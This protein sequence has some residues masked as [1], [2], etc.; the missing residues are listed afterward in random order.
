MSTALEGVL[1]GE[2][3]ALH[4]EQMGERR[5]S[6]HAGERGMTK[7]GQFG[8]SHSAFAGCSRRPRR[9]P[10]AVVGSSKSPGGFIP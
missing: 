8:P 7:L 6:E 5:V 2:G 4:K 10:R 9:A 3:T 1:D